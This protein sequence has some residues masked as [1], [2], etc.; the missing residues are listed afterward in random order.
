MSHFINLHLTM[1]FQ[2]L[3]STLHK[4]VATTSDKPH[5][6]FQVVGNNLFLNGMHKLSEPVYYI[7]VGVE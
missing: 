7:F 5:T 1:V 3:E 6:S 4:L 2:Y